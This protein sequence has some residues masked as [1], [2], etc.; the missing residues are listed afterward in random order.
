VDIFVRIAGREG[1][2]L[3]VNSAQEVFLRQ[4]A[5]HSAP[6]HA[7]MPLQLGSEHV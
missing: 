3:F 6:V 5:G 4:T 2:H 7:G 1:E